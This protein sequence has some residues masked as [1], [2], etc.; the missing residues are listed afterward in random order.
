[1]KKLSILLLLL[2]LIIVGCNSNEEKAAELIKKELSKTLYDFDSYSPIETIVTEAKQSVYTDTTLWAKA[3]IAL[4]TF[5]LASDYLEKANDAKEHM[6][7]YGPPT[8]YSS[9]HSDRK[10]YKYKEEWSENMEKATTSYELF[11]V[12][13]EGLKDTLQIVNTEK[14]VGWEVKHRFRCK[15]KGG[16]STI[17]DYR[18]VMDEDFEKVLIHEDM[19][20]DDSKN[21]RD[22]IK[23]IIDGGLEQ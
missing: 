1:M 16:H 6:E 8:S 19:D 15:T 21:I 13:A 17:G 18:Y 7:I 12:I 5:N 20:D 3:N 4:Y 11:K 2:P 9:S 23:F 22:M 14:I 10:Y